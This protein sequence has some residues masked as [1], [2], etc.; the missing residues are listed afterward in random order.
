MTHWTPLIKTDRR[1]RL[2]ILRRIF[3]RR[4]WVQIGKSVYWFGP[5][6]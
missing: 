3:W 5:R 6:G 4:E 1:V 2:W